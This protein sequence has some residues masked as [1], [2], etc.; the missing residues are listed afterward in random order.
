MTHEP[1]WVESTTARHIH[2][3]QLGTF[4]GLDGVRDN[5]MLESALARPINLWHYERA[6]IARLAAAYAFGIAMN[7]PFIDGNKRT[8]FVVSV[9][10]VEL[11][12]FTFSAGE[13]ESA[14]T[15]L[16]LAAGEMG[17]QELAEWFETWMAD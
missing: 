16:S 4:G 10:F 15:F 7:H 5:G 3:L 1:I 13:V 8:A 12:G 17:E 14:A 6:S 9:L 11:N 2:R